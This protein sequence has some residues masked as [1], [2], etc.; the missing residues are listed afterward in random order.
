MFGDW[1]CSLAV[2]GA[3]SRFGRNLL[4]PKVAMPTEHRL[5]FV[6]AFGIGGMTRNTLFLAICIVLVIT[7]TA[8]I[9]NV[10]L[11]SRYH[12]ATRLPA[13]T[14]ETQALTA[15]P[16]PETGGMM[17]KPGLNFTALNRDGQFVRFPDWT[18]WA[19]ATSGTMIRLPSSLSATRSPMATVF[20]ESQR[21]AS[22]LAPQSGC[23]NLCRCGR[24]GPGRR[25]N[26]AALPKNHQDVTP[27]HQDR[28]V[29]GLLW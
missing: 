8:A 22:V 15:F 26:C 23:R 4:W 18:G 21:W 10:W 14:L 24:A 19:S 1:S 27:T 2:F 11:N 3:T 16:D 12:F 17:L 13:A 25:S 20:R 6:N 28:V 9:I 29:D 5:R 7:A